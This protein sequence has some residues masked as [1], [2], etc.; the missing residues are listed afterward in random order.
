MHL[1]ESI[2]SSMNA[3]LRVRAV[4]PLISNKLVD[5]SS[6]IEIVGCSSSE[7][8]CELLVHALESIPIFQSIFHL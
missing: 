4:G 8:I 1:Q 6:I 2:L 7:W 3:V 5:P